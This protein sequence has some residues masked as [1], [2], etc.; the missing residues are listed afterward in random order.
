[1]NPAI[2]LFLLLGG[3][4]GCNFLFMKQ[5]AVIVSPLQVTLLRAVFGFLPLLI[6]AA[7]RGVLKRSHL[8]HWPHFLVMSVLATAFYYYAFAEGSH[9]LPSALAGML[10]GSIGLFTYLASLIFLRKEEPINAK[11]A[12]GTALALAGVALI[13]KPWTADAAQ[14]QLSGTLFVIAGAASIGLS[15]VYAKKFIMPLEIPALALTTYQLGFAMLVL[16]AVTPFSGMAALLQVPYALSILIVGLGILGTG[17]AYIIYYRLVAAFGAIAASSVTY[18]PPIVALVI[19][20]LIGEKLDGSD[21]AA[22]LL[23]LAGVWLLQKARMAK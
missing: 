2:G 22:M 8:R 21:F 16:A 14:A 6:F 12:I 10:S 7:W 17:T 11:S 9:R 4:W 23:I 3:I 18:L 20:L 5:A 19:G 15:F 13:A 1:M